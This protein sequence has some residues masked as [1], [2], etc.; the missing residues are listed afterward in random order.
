[1]EGL[2]E[3]YSADLAQKI[4]RGLRESALKGHVF[5]TPI[6]GLKKNDDGFCILD[7]GMAK[8][9]HEAFFRYGKK[10]RKTKCESSPFRKEWLEEFVLFHTKYDVLT[11]EMIEK[12]ADAVMDI[13][14]Q[15]SISFAI[16]SFEDELKNVQKS[17]DNL[18]KAMMCLLIE[19]LYIKIKWSLLTTILQ[20]M[21][22]LSTFKTSPIVFGFVLMKWSRRESNP[23]P[24]AHSSYFY[25]HSQFFDIPST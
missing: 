5:G 24:K 22:E 1:M 21:T 14:K 4:N 13:Q 2:A 15:D 9:M 11:D 18:M 8:I 7:E 12:L 19:F 3:Y 17:I 10:H 25:Y 20:T 23:C 6:C 16:K